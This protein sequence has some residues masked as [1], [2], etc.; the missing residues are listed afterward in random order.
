M[1]I[2]LNSTRQNDDDITVFFTLT[3]GADTFKWHAD[4]PIM[5]ESDILAYLESRIETYRCGI[6]RKQYRDAVVTPINGETMLDAW[7]RWETENDTTENPIV[8]TKWR[9]TH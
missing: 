5:A 9:D 1:N 8:K 4:I 3:D 6:Y 7:K 2:T